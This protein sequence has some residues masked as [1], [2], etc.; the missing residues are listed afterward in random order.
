MKER[1]QFIL[2]RMRERLWIKPLLACLFSIGAVFFAHIADGTGLGSYVLD[3]TNESIESLLKI[4]A[5]SMLVIATFAV[6]SMVSAYASASSSATPR[7]FSLIIAD[8]VSQNALSTFIGVFIFSVIALV[9][10]MNGYYGKAGRF[11]LFALTI[12]MF[13]LVVITFARWVDAIARLGRLGNTIDK[14]EKATAKAIKQRQA[15]PFLG[16]AAALPL[17]QG[18]QPIYANSIGYMQRLNMTSL[19]AHAEKLNLKI[20]VAALPGAFCTPNRPV[21]HITAQDHGALT[22]EDVEALAS[23]FVI[24]DARAFDQDPRFGLVV[25]SEIASRALSPAVN[26]PGTA[27]DV[28]GT[29]VR[30]FALWEARAKSEETSH[31][32]RCD[33]IAVPALSMSDMFEDAFTGIARDGAG[34]VEV[35]VRLEKALE[36]LS[37]MEDGH[38]RENAILHARLAL[39]RAESAM[40]LPQ[41]VAAVRKAARFATH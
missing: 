15:A 18:S 27:I 32:V 12:L 20:T 24:G 40:T 33:R 23:A 22:D 5:A 1:W 30:L 39:T 37:T 17:A 41:D 19:Q 14:V 25:L 26:D 28:V 2:N 21:A 16:G 6:G 7:S 9:A 34:A 38:M 8:D 11:T 36:A 10:L 3:I 35:V 4:I 13:V 31:A 29:L